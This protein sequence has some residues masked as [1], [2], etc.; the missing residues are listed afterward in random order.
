MADLNYYFGMHPLG[1]V[2]IVVSATLLYL[3]FAAIL[4]RQGQ[5]LYASPSVFDLAIVTML[6]AV[7]GRAILGQV[8]TLAG[9]L[10]ALG[11]LFLVQA[12]A[13]RVGRGGGSRND[14]QHRAIA[15]MVNGQV[16]GEALDGRRI[17]EA[18]LWSALRGAGVRSPAEVALVVLEADGRFS[19]L[20]TGEP[21]DPAL[22]TG[23]RYADDLR[24]RVG[25]TEEGS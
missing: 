11:T 14:D 18:T 10:L 20:R 5:R 24:A 12:V 2:A 22:L 25:A 6:G 9:G 13:G 19:I 8:P 23:V 15:V 21:I 7:V 16:D 4:N 17:P 1:A 3:A